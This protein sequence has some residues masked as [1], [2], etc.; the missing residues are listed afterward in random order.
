MKKCELI[1]SMQVDHISNEY[2]ILSSISHPFI[3]P[4]VSPRLTLMGS[5]KTQ[6]I[7]IFSWSSFQEDNCSLIFDRK[8]CLRLIKL[9][10]MRHT[11][12]LS[13]STFTQKILF[14]G[15]LNLKIFSL[16]QMDTWN[17]QT[18]GLLKLLKIGLLLCVVLLSIW[19]PRYCKIRD[20]ENQLTGGH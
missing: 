5:P 1:K 14:T 11:S 15:I 6:D 9:H 10:F 8:G 13:L 7:C 2:K 4:F 16:D 20:M 3:V 17:W 18:L 19:L 12:Y